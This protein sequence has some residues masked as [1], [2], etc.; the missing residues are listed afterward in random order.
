MVPPPSPYL[1]PPD[2]ATKKTNTPHHPHPHHPHP[3]PPPSPP[4]LHCRM[5]TPAPVEDPSTIEL[6][7]RVLERQ[8]D[9]LVREVHSLGTEI[10]AEVRALRYATIGVAALGM[11]LLAGVVGVSIAI[12]APGV[13]VSTPAP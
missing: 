8:T 6:L 2:A 5:P 11:V 1:I 4:V 12:D 3:P 7:S 13:H 10:R 9:A